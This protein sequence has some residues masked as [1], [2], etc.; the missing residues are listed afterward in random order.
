MDSMSPRPPVQRWSRRVASFAGRSLLA[1]A[2]I[3]LL[4]YGL[5]Q[6]VFILMRAMLPMPSMMSFGYILNT[7]EASPPVHIVGPVMIDPVLDTTSPL[8]VVFTV[9]IVVL[10]ILGI[11]VAGFVRP[12]RQ[13]LSS[14]EEKSLSAALPPF[15]EIIFFLHKY[16][17]VLVEGA[18]MLF[19]FA[20]ACFLTSWGLSELVIPILVGRGGLMPVVAAVEV[21]IYIIP[22]VGLL[23]AIVGVGLMIWY[24]G[25]RW[26]VEPSTEEQ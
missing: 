5:V 12:L 26:K 3:M 7:L 18:E 16:R 20:V 4:G 9:V 2:S 11:A 6:F 14:T 10:S 21:Y 22:V 23:C 15:Q 24:T 19:V 13:S 8:S 25:L 1:T 17:N